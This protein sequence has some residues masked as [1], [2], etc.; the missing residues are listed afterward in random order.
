ME[1][2]IKR[3][4]LNKLEQQVLFIRNS[5]EL[6]DRGHEEE[7]LR[8]AASLRIVF[9]DTDRS[10]S[11]VR[12]LKLEETGTRMLSTAR[13]HGDWKDY[14]AHKIDLTSSEPVKM[15]PMLGN[16]FF[17]RS[18]EDWWEKETVFVHNGTKYSR[19]T[20]VL[21]A[22]NKDGGTH[23]DATLEKYYEV[24]CAGEYAIGITGD[25]K[26]DG[27][28]PFPQGVTFFPKNAH[29]ALLRQFAHEVLAS[30]RHFA[31]IKE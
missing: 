22:A 9:H 29:L 19:R 16:N 2:L 5:C 7:A 27:P 20:I 23:V 18:I 28:P 11:L 14:L 4:L 12:H 17:E 8:L 21:S 24:L 1:K 15:T 10:T 25:L 3:R 30:V 6:F 26:F 13:G 31:W